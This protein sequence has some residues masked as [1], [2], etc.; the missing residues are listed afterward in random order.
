M[1][2]AELLV[3]VRDKN[4]VNIKD[5]QGIDKITRARID[6]CA[7]LSDII[8]I[9]SSKGKLMQPRWRFFF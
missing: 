5:R 6:V 2:I 7:S 9:I 4:I 8:I 3:S 1:F